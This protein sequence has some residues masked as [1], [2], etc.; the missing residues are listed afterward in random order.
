MSSFRTPTQNGMRE[1]TTTRATASERRE[2]TDQQLQQ[3]AADM[4]EAEKITS[5]D[6]LHRKLGREK[7]PSGFT[8]VKMWLP[9]KVDVVLTIRLEELDEVLGLPIIRK[10]LTI[11]GDMRFRMHVASTEMPLRYAAGLTAEPGIFHSAAEVLNVMARLKSMPPDN[12]DLK[13]AAAEL[14]DRAVDADGA[15]EL[16]VCQFAAEQLR[17]A[18][19]PPNRRRYSQAL[20]SLA[21]VWDRTSPKLYEDL[22]HSGV[23]VLPHKTT[24]RRLTSALSVREGLEIGTVT[25]LKMRVAGLNQRERLVNLAMDEVH[26][27]RAVEL[28]G[29]RLH[30]DSKNGVTNTIFCTLISSVA[31]N[32]E[33]IVTMSPVPS[34]TTEAI[35]E[36]FFKVVKTLT[37][38]GFI[39]VSCTTDGHRTNQSFHNSLGDDGKHPE[40]ILNPYSTDSARI[41]TM[42]DTVHLFK[43]F[44]YNLLNKKTLACPPMPGT[45]TPL[46]ADSKHL[47]QV[48]LMELGGEVKMAHRLT[49]R[50]LHPTSVE[51]VNVRLAMAATHESTVAALRFYSQRD[52]HSHMRNFIYKGGCRCNP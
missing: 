38:I 17:L 21:V 32:Y 9:N 48:H 22:C 19:V 8:I 10:N 51:R 36:I 20:M 25:Y 44:Y 6:D 5:L 15:D 33:D 11:Y 29:G 12:M 26:T 2:A 16:N 43:N 41:Y 52:G 28:A 49:D 3:Q 7:L 37:E 40:W 39:I 30:G 24:L 34:I 14:L 31:G 45:E 46:H 27:A 42:Y 47:E 23:V 4:L 18:S 50:V 35:R 13:S 1:R